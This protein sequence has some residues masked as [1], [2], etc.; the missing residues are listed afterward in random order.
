MHTQLKCF[1]YLNIFITIFSS[2]Y[3]L[4][5]YIWHFRFYSG[6]LNFILIL[7]WLISRKITSVLMQIITTIIV[8]IYIF[9]FTMNHA[10]LSSLCSSHPAINQRGAVH[11][12]PWHHHCSL[13]VRGRVQRHF[14]RAAVHHLHRPDQFHQWVSCTYTQVWYQ[15]KRDLSSRSHGLI[16]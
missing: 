13:D 9:C 2:S 4:Y 15:R 7:G 16:T 1:F 5:F 8:T 11:R 14:L 3:L 6:A 12:L 10:V